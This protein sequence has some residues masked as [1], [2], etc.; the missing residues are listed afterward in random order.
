MQLLNKPSLPSVD[1]Q[2]N[3][4]FDGVHLDPE[5]I[6]SD[7]QALLRLLREM[8]SA[9]KENKHLSIAIPARLPVVGEM[10]LL[11]HLV[12]SKEYCTAVASEVDSVA[13]M[14]YDSA[15]PAAFLYRS[16]LQ[17]QIVSLT[18]VL[19]GTQ[20]HVYIGIP[21]SEETTGAHLPWAEDMRAGLRGVVAGLNDRES[22]PDVITGVAIY[23]YWET[24][25]DEWQT[26]TELWLEQTERH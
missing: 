7:D 21:T 26:Y 4:G 3:W 8:R 24:T 23:P 14:T 20:A 6:G 13:A 1:W 15:M 9:L 11:N 12:W 18:Q 19:D 2:W 10:P 17:L 25:D 16:W 22:H 5:P